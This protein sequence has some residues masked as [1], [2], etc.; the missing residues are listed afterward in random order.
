MRFPCHHLWWI[1][2]DKWPIIQKS[3][4]WS[5]GVFDMVSRRCWSNSRIASDLV[6]R[7]ALL[8]S[9]LFY[10][11]SGMIGCVTQY[12]CDL[13]FFKQDDFP[14]PECEAEAYWV[15]VEMRVGSGAGKAMMT[16]SNGNIFCVTGP[17]CGEFTGHRWIPLTKAS[18][19][20]LWC[21]L[22]SLPKSTVE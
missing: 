20:E 11:F 8:T 21:I 18:D 16:S 4:P 9:M 14:T 15:S 17:L 3:F 10:S 1:P 22:W 19:A 13:L 7:D 12:P 2:F 5:F 6:H